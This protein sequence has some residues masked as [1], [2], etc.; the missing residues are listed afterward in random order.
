MSAA[1]HLDASTVSDFQALETPHLSG[2]KLLLWETL[3]E[4][5]AIAGVL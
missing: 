3:F 2:P 4:M 1:A 5:S